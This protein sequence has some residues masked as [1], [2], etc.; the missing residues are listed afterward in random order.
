MIDRPPTIDELRRGL[1]TLLPYLIAAAVYVGLGVWE[2]RFLLSWAEGI[3][4][5]FVAV[6]A[7]PQIIK[8]VR[9]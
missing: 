8:R 1:R 3:L 5:C 9:H 6:W 4:F 7:V 2:P